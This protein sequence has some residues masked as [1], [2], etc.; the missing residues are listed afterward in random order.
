MRTI[1]CGFNQAITGAIYFTF[2]DGK[3][4]SFDRLNYR[5]IQVFHLKIS[6]KTKRRK[7]IRFD[8]Q[9]NERENLSILSSG[10][11]IPR[12]ICTRFGRYLYST[13]YGWIIIPISKFLAHDNDFPAF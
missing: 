13:K 8:K 12:D 4:S 2:H 6:V 3:K 5:S 10:V 7:E 1:S 9:E 11:Q